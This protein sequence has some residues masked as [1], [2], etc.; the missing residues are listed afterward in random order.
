MSTPSSRLLS[1]LSLLQARRDWPGGVLADRLGV[2][3]RTVRRDVDRLRELGYPVHASKGP[4]GGY[5]LD[6]GTQMP[7]L[8][9]DDDQA[10]ALVV[11]LQTASTGVAGVDEAAV[12]ALATLRQVMPARL[13]TAADA[14][15]VT[16][17]TRRG[18]RPEVDQH[19][20]LAVG[21]AVR[22]REVLRFD[23]AGGTDAGPRPARRA[24]A[25][26]LVT[27][28]D[29]WYLV[30]YDLERADWRTFRV[31]R[32]TPKSGSGPRF[33][34]RPLPASDVAAF[35]AERFAAVTP[36]PCRGEAEV[37]MPATEVATWAG[38]DA[39][40][41]PLGQDRSR[42]A[43]SAWSWDGVAARFAMFGVP[44]RVIGPPELADAMRRL[45]DRA[46][47]SLGA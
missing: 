31:D 28:G 19:V 20:L 8:L 5:R 18:N 21:A 16:A 47:A 25:H 46:T 1:L 13:R 29:R 40:V 45:A 35:V 9:L 2:S 27:W 33:A 32:M 7:P 22:A 43:L 12:R 41:E 38:R 24:E 6:A 34:P 11:A 37:D 4:D 42:A 39:L 30:G 14:L 10:V 26:H 17:V 3:P 36:W 15:Q 23:Y 44:L